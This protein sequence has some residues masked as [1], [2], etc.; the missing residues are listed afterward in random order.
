MNDADK[1]LTR[2]PFVLLNHVAE[3]DEEGKARPTERTL[4]RAE[5]VASARSVTRG[6]ETCTR[7]NYMQRG[8]LQAITVQESIDH[9][10]DL[11]GTLRRRPEQEGSQGALVLLTALR[12]ASRVMLMSDRTP[13]FGRP[14]YAGAELWV[15][16]V[17]GG[18][19]DAQL[20]EL[21]RQGALAL[22]G[23]PGG[24]S[25]VVLKRDVSEAPASAEG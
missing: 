3:V 10:A 5:D 20:A 18:L 13:V 15:V 17:A 16:A 4:V 1:P 22:D 21:G 11:L 24:P 25:R 6:A 2:G 12:T 7:V 8:Q 9:L 19:D 14:A 23:G